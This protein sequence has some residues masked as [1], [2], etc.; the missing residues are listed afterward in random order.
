MVLQIGADGMN[1][2]VRKACEFHT[3]RS[4]YGQSGLVATLKL[5]GVCIKTK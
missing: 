5:R 1:S 4:D 3:L 2:T